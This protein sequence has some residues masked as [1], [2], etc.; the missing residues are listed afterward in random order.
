[1]LARSGELHQQGRVT[2][3]DSD[4]RYHHVCICKDFSR[5]AASGM[6]IDKHDVGLFCVDKQSTRRIASAAD[7]GM[8]L[9]QDG[10]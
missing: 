9:G 3:H 8:Q 7:L 10:A 5:P 1:M 6:T 2:R 4:F